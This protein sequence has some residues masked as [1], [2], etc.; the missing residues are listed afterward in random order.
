MISHW[1]RIGIA[2]VPLALA[3]AASN[4]PHEKSSAE[5][6]IKGILAHY[7]FDGN[8]S[9]DCGISGPFQL[10]NTRFVRNTL[11]LNGC[12]EHGGDYGYRAIAKVPGLNYSSFTI[13][14][15]FKPLDT[16]RR[17]NI[18]TRLA[19]ISFEDTGNIITGGTSCRW[20][21]IRRN[22]NEALEITLN[23][24]DYIRTYDDAYISS[25]AWNRVT[26]CVDLDNLLIRT[27]FNGRKLE[28]V[29]LP[30]DFVLRVLDSKSEESD[31]KLTFTNYS[32]G[33]TFRGCVDNLR[34]FDRG[35]EDEDVLALSF[36][37]P[38]GKRDWR[39]MIV[40]IIAA[41]CLLLLGLMF[42]LMKKK[43]QE[44]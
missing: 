28:D 9:D 27:F 39:D 10:S 13:S 35:L 43:W 41:L 37:H 14:L 2:L 20:F 42:H 12:Y 29:H 33:R 16:S 8:G 1:L 7:K 44:Q 5:G 25:K 19:N 17:I 4:S 26:C 24:Q 36:E 23:N 38:L 15:E 18:L 11:Y 6:L 31:R 34:V 21:G 30:G 3:E 22:E 32:N 40:W